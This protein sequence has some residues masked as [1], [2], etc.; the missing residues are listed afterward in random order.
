MCDLTPVRIGA[1]FPLCLIFARHSI[2]NLSP[3]ME[4]LSHRARWDFKA[5]Q[6]SSP[7]WQESEK[8]RDEFGL[9][10]VRTWI[11]SNARDGLKASLRL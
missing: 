9:Q 3:K 4:L 1:A 2:Y 6:I 7:L 8:A 5:L 11:I 10:E